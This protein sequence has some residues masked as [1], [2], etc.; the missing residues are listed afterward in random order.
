MDLHL[1]YS[2]RSN[3]S[4]KLDGYADADYVNDK[5]NHKSISGFCYFLFN[6][7]SPVSYSSKKQSLVT[8]SIME[9]ETTVMMKATK[10]GL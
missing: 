3:Q 1:K 4:P 8:L 2:R 5:D 10:E 6:D 9:A 7:S